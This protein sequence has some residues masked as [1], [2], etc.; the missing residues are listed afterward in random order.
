MKL[1]TIDRHGMVLN[2]SQ[3]WHQIRHGEIRHNCGGCHAHSQQPTAFELTAAAGPDYQVWDLTKNIPLFASKRDG[4]SSRKWDKNDQTDVRL[5]DGSVKDVE[6]Y[7][8][9]KPL[10]DRSCVACHAKEGD[11]RPQVPETVLIH[12]A[13]FATFNPLVM[14]SKGLLIE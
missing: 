2:M 4:T 1:E 7:R 3:T 11:G 8:D 6:F 5:T 14:S 12:Q 13:D 9:I 10:L